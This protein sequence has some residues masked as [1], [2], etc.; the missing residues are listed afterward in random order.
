[1]SGHARD[2]GALPR[3]TQ[4]PRDT[5]PIGTELRRWRNEV[6]A[7]R[8]CVLDAPHSVETP[9]GPRCPVRLINF[10]EMPVKRGIRYGWATPM[11]DKSADP[12]HAP[13]LLE[14]SASSGVVIVMEAPNH[15]DT[16]NPSKG[17]ITCETDT[18]ETGKFIL[19]L[20]E[21]IH[22]APDDV[23]LTNTVQCLP[24]RKNDRYPVSAPQRQNCQQHLSRLFEILRPRV[25]IAFG[26]EALQALHRFHPIRIDGT[27]QRAAALK[28]SHLAAKPIAPWAST[29]LLPLFHPGPIVRANA[30]RKDGTPGTGRSA[31][32]QLRDFRIVRR[33]L[34]E[35]P[36]PQPASA[37]QPRRSA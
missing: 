37:A 35:M 25:V 19:A 1:M 11:L 23:V 15:D 29:T 18:D 4:M 31:E 33:L 28:V 36:A 20:L 2:F 21:S 8:V 12:N 13:E 34:D 10:D 32:Q 24:A 14:R 27:V 9:N 30:R 5:R 26:N 16:Y 6:H 17:H 7:C 3:S 22:L